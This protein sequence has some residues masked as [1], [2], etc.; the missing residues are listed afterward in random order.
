MKNK[1]Y[2]FIITRPT[3]DTVRGGDDLI[4]MIS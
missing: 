2:Y 1:D 3:G 4:S